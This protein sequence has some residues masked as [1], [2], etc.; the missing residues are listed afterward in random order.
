MIGIFNKLGISPSYKALIEAVRSN[1][2]AALVKLS[3]VGQRNQAMWV[4]Y[5]NLTYTTNVRDTRLFNRADFVILTCVYIVVPHPS[6]ARP[7]LSQRDCDYGALRKLR[8]DDFLPTRYSYESIRKGNMHIVWSILKQFG[9]QRGSAMPK[10]DFPLPKL[11]RLDPSKRPEILP[12][13]TFNLNEGI[14]S[15]VIQIIEQVSQVLG[16]SQEQKE[17]CLIPFKGDQATSR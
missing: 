7:M 1:A 3:K 5:D 12:L 11:Y 14:I 2:R 10:I 6:M 4:S 15:K 17:E 13:P 9:L 8:L 16:L